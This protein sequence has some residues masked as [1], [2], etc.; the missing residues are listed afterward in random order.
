[1]WFQIQATSKK[2][3]K[4]LLDKHFRASRVLHSAFMDNT[5]CPQVKDFCLYSL[6][7]VVKSDFWLSH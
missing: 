1:M 6:C 7:L 5:H 4:L 2:G 3:I